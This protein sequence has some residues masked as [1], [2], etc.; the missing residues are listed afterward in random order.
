MRAQR[1]SKLQCRPLARQAVCNDKCTK[2]G[3]PCRGACKRFS[4]YSRL[5][6]VQL[7]APGFS[8]LDRTVLGWRNGPRR[9]FPSCIMRFVGDV[10]GNSTVGYQEPKRQKRE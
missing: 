3:Q 8:V 6:Y 9:P 7:C 2:D 10:Y 1:S 5:A 4:V